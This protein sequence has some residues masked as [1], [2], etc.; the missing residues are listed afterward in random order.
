MLA[1]G[2][3]ASRRLLVRAAPAAA[4]PAPAALSTG[5]EGYYKTSTG[6]VGLKAN[7]NARADLIAQQKALLDKIKVQCS[8][9]LVGGC[10][11]VWMDLLWGEVVPKASPPTHQR[12]E[13]RCDC[14]HVG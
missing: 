1:L 7:P 13:E 4:R 2:R 3:A 5:L 12:P 11:C 14:S 8:P 6:L 9:A 10:V